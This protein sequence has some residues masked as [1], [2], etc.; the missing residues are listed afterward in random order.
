[1]TPNNIKIFKYAC[2]WATYLSTLPLGHGGSPQYSIFTRGRNILFLW[3]LKARAKFEP[4]ISYFPSRQLY[5][6]HQGPNTT[7]TH[8]HRRSFA[9]RCH[10]G[11][12]DHR[13]FG[14]SNLQIIEHSDRQIFGLSIF[15][16][17][18]QNK[19]FI[20]PR[21]C[22]TLNKKMFWTHLTRDVE[23]MCFLRLA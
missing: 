21:I 20:C 1:M 3:N 15:G 5:P 17:L 8:L 13:T 19:R 16:L 12:S 9:L 14:S 18:G 10:Q 6:L 22:A 23:A 2:L 4:A 7:Y 11:N